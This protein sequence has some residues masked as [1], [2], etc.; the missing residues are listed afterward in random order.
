MQ[1][2]CKLQYTVHDFIVVHRQWNIKMFIVHINYIQQALLIFCLLLFLH[3]SDSWLQSP[4]ATA[5]Q[6]KMM[7]TLFW[8]EE[9][10]RQNAVHFVMPSGY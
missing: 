2:C 9:D 4:I 5:Q 10:L 7:K 1:L 3:L 8:V 6:K